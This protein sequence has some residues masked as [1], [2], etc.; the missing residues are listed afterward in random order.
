MTEAVLDTNILVRHLT[1]DPPEI[2]SRVSA[3]LVAAQARTLDLVLTPVVIA[4]TAYVLA[5]VYRWQRPEIADGLLALVTA[6]NLLVVEE[7]IMVN[8]LTAYRDIRGLD[9]AD[10]YVAA[11]ALA[12]HHGN[13]MS[14]DRDFRRVAGISVL[15]DP[16]Q[17][18]SA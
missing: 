10:A 15:N 14:V 3:L 5:S 2:A 18:E 11:L 17:L 1:N 8:A 4:E 9:V 7:A 13:V 6:S 12:R 16:R